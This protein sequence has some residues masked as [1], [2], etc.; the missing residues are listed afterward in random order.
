MD[1]I[2]FKTLSFVT[3]LGL[4]PWDFPV[5]KITEF[6]K[7]CLSPFSILKQNGEIK[8]FLPKSMC[9]FSASL[10]R[11]YVGYSSFWRNNLVISVFPSTWALWKNDQYLFLWHME[12]YSADWVVVFIVEKEPGKKWNKCIIMTFGCIILSISK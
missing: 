8:I 10:M 6:G 1:S 2:W 9:Y 7:I 3:L 4:Q 12:T 5:L 11:V